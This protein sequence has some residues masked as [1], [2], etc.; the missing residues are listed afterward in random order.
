MAGHDVH[1]LARGA[2][3]QAIRAEGLRVESILGDFHVHPARATDKP[4]E[5]GVV[6]W[7]LCAVKTWQLDEAI[8][9]MTPLLGAATAILPLQN[10]VTAADRVAAALGAERVL[11]AAT[12]IR[13]EIAAPG[14]IR[15]AGVEPRIALG[16]LDGAARSR[17]GALCEALAGAG[18]RAEVSESI[19]DV[20]W[21]KFL[22]IA[23]TSAVGAA[24]RATV[25]ELRAIPETRALAVT[26]MDEIA[27]L[28]RARGIALSP[29]T[30]AD[31]VAFLD[32][33][34][35]STTSSMQR[36]LI[37]GRPSELEDLCGAVVHMGRESG[38]RTP[39]NDFLYATLLP[40]EARATS[41]S[42]SRR[43]PA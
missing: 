39:V 17:T 24:A 16:E 15:H 38:V 30:L 31:T 3:L 11:A 19:R 20:L 27:A 14:L 21:T 4:A 13:A 34:P 12:W 41:K 8:A 5:I 29:E 9:A 1:F 32:R 40:Q 2:H 37:A 6:D 22:F 10:G 35:A 18:V 42:S 28:G 36:D 26:A 33:L 43:A 25:G 23:A 7:V